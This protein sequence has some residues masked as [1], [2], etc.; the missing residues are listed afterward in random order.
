MQAVIAANTNTDIKNRRNDLIENFLCNSILI[1]IHRP[2][3]PSSL[4]QGPGDEPG[5]YHSNPKKSGGICILNV[6]EIYLQVQAN[7]RNIVLKSCPAILESLEWFPS[8]NVITASPYFIHPPFALHGHFRFDQSP[9]L[10]SLR[11]T[12]VGKTVWRTLPSVQGQCS[13]VDSPDQTLSEK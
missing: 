5:K 13:P 7:P 2:S 6:H 11:R 10:Y 3:L 9:L 4:V 8:N 12:G 1:E